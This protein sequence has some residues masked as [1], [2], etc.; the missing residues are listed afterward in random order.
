MTQLDTRLFINPLT[1]HITSDEMLSQLTASFDNLPFTICFTDLEYKDKK[2]ILAAAEAK[3][4]TSFNITIA[5]LWDKNIQQL[6]LKAK[7]TIIISHKETYIINKNDVVSNGSTVFFEVLDHCVMKLSEDITGFNDRIISR[8]WKQY[9]GNISIPDTIIGGMLTPSIMM[10]RNIK[11]VGEFREPDQILLNF[12]Y[13]S[14]H[15][16]AKF[17]RT[18]VHEYQHFISNLRSKIIGDKATEKNIG[19][20]STTTEYNPNVPLDTEDVSVSWGA[21]L[22][23]IQAVVME[24][25]YARSPEIPNFFIDFLLEASLKILRRFRAN[26]ITYEQAMKAIILNPE[27]VPSKFIEH[28]GNLPPNLIWL[29]KPIEDRPTDLT[30]ERWKKAGSL[31]RNLVFRWAIANKRQIMKILRGESF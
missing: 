24:R 22:E 12:E 8:E 31:V 20:K 18:L 27:N 6:M 1:E 14:K 28:V 30:P 7:Y 2:L 29:M 19:Y 21:R 5:N 23:E 17:K 25:L 11:S 3:T 13:L 26:E 10:L 16:A 15:G 9:H 4:I